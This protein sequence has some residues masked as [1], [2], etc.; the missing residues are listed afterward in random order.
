MLELRAE[1]L[2][3]LA[4]ATTRSWEEAQGEAAQRLGGSTALLTLG[5]GLLVQSP[6]T[7]HFRCFKPAILGNVYTVQLRPRFFVNLFLPREPSR[8]R[9]L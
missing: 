8:H 6:E 7:I 4:P 2:R 1:N 9:P 5:F 3:G